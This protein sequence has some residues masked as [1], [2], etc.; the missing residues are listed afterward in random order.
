MLLI[1]QIEVYAPEYMGKMDVLVGA[2]QVIA[3][4]ETLSN[5][6]GIDE[7]N[8]DGLK[9]TPGFIDPHVHFSG[10]GG[11]GGPSSRTP[12]MQ[13]S[14]F[15][16]AGVTSVVGC[17]GTDGMTRTVESVL[18]KAKSLRCEGLSTWIYTGAYQ[19]PTPTITGDPGKDIALIEEVIGVGEVAISDHRSSVPTM[20]ELIRLT[21]HARVGGMLGGKAGIVNIH[22]GDAKNPFKPLIDAVENSELNFKQFLPTHCNRNDYIFEDAKTYGK[23][24]LI[25]ITTS[26]YPYFPDEEIKPSTGIKLLVEAGVPAEHITCSSDAGGSLPAFNAAGELTKLDL[27][28]PSANQNEFRDLVF[29]EKFSIEKALLFFSTNAAKTLKLKNKGKIRV[30][31]D[32]DLILYDKDLRIKHLIVNGKIMIREYIRTVKGTYE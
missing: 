29:N 22:M 32:A 4:Q 12:E 20:H 18:M 3:M 2:N 14:Q 6:M 9:L 25:D 28:M 21:E 11:E 13:L 27:G 19:V 10:A 1:K 5:N 26:A 31:G 8:G 16:D 30:G 7:I 17:L 24:G 15:I 23:N